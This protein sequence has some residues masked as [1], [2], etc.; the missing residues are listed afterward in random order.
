M[1][2]HKLIM[3]VKEIHYKGRKI[4]S[5]LDDTFML[6]A[7]KLFVTACKSFSEAQTS[8]MKVKGHHCEGT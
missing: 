3:R 1:N 8:N 6:K 7:H 4:K 2:T 5:L